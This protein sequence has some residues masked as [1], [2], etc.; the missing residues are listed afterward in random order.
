MLFNL[1]Q[2]IL[3]PSFRIVKLFCCED[4]FSVMDVRV[5]WFYKVK[6]F[7][8]SFSYDGPE[9]SCYSTDFFATLIK[10]LLRKSF[11]CYAHKIF[12]KQKSFF[13]TL[14]KSLLCKF[15]NVFFFCSNLSVFCFFHYSD[16]QP[17]FFFCYSSY[18]A[19]IFIF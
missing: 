1:S 7:F 10:F 2:V 3:I 15:C 11:F 9:E 13:A 16:F 8:L 19:S 12:A 14:I 18:F 4:N 17:S 5:H 6:M